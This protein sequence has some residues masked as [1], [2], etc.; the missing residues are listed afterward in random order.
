MAANII[1]VTAIVAYG[2][3]CIWYL[4]NEHRKARARGKPVSCISCP[5]FKECH[6]HA[7]T[8]P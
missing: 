4:V 1:C 6:C 3:F 2:L 7:R 5:A 8:C